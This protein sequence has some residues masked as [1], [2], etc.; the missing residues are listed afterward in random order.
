MRNHIFYLIKLRLWC[1]ILVLICGCTIKIPLSKNI[2]FQNPRG[3]KIPKKVCVIVSKEEAGKV[4]KH[5]GTIIESPLRF[6]V[7][8]SISTNLPNAMKTMFQ[9]VDFSNDFP[10]EGSGCDY[11]V[12]PTFKSFELYHGSAFSAKKVD[13]F[14]DYELLGAEKKQISAINTKGSSVR[15]RTGAEKTQVVLA[16]VFPVARDAMFKQDQRAIGEAWDM[17]LADSIVQLATELE[18][19]ISNKE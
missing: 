15:A 12:V 9:D 10:G 11:Y 16:G 7:G 8:E 13:A 14:I 2:V 18:K 19:Y 5:K 4:V 1:V 6:D 3:E 17:A